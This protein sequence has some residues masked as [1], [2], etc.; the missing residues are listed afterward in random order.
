MSGE[1]DTGTRDFRPALG[2]RGEPDPEPTP[3]CGGCRQ[4]LNEFGPDMT[5][6]VE[7]G[8]G[9]RAVW[10]LTEILPHAFGPSNLG[11]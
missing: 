11:K 2:T 5:V 10:R 3:P 9:E 6:T 7:S 1:D 4:V 8:T